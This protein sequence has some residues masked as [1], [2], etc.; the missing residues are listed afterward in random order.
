MAL[1]SKFS[2]SL[3]MCVLASLVFFFSFGCTEQH[4]GSLFPDQGLNPLPLQW[5]LSHILS[6]WPARE[7]LSFGSLVAD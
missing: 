3:F 4:V 6:Y 1:L 2:Y 5:S 7:V